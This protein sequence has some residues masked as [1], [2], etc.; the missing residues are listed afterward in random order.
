MPIYLGSRKVEET[1]QQAPTLQDGVRR[2]K[3]EDRTH[4][5]RLPHAAVREKQLVG[6]TNRKVFLLKGVLDQIIDGL[7][8]LALITL[9]LYTTT[10][11]ILLTGIA[12]TIRHALTLTA[13]AYLPR[14]AKRIMDVKKTAY[15]AGVLAGF[16]FILT[17]A[18]S[19]IG[20]PF[21]LTTLIVLFSTATGVYA[22]A[23]RLL[24]PSVLGKTVHGRL[25]RFILYYGV[26]L[27]SIAMIL[28]SLA[29]RTTLAFSVYVTLTGVLLIIAAYL[30]F[31][32]TPYR[33]RV[34]SQEDPLRIV[35]RALQSHSPFLRLMLLAGGI[36]TSLALAYPPLIVIDAYKVF[37]QQ[38]GAVL[39]IFA[40][41]LLTSTLSPL[42]FDRVM[43]RK[44]GRTSF[45]L[46]GNGL[47]LALPAAFILARMQE[48]LFLPAAA[49]TLF[50]YFILFLAMAGFGIAGI[51]L[52]RL[53]LDILRED[54]QRILREALRMFVTLA[55]PLLTLLILGLSETSLLIGHILALITALI[56]FLFVSLLTARLEEEH[57]RRLH[58]LVHAP[59]SHGSAEQRARQATRA[60]VQ[61]GR[62]RKRT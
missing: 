38:A 12:L 26:I 15:L 57:F 54:E 58:V 4:L 56:P 17:G 30:T 24:L 23:S 53:M 55:T 62:T 29:F 31:I 33:E 60:I 34:V 3:Q 18:A 45:F 48:I 32:L 19:L 16:L 5:T 52:S 7:T 6:E 47:V 39:I 37:H 8:S 59:P 20:N 22:R 25:Q 11:N 10:Q 43:L 1:L 2:V 51:A 44:R 28:S 50:P 41:A 27:A 61:R 36:L 35:R 14:F 42:F 13:E 49:R 40:A 9:L 46:L 21:V